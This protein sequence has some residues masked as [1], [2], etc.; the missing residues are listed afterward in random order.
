MLALAARTPRIGARARLLETMP[1]SIP[2]PGEG[3]W[4]PPGIQRAHW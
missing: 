4:Q 2:A 3:T 1:P